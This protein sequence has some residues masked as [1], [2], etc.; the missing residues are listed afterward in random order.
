[1]QRLNGNGR[2]E[3]TITRMKL[4]N[5]NNRENIEKSKTAKIRA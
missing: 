3:S 2:T 5:L 4:S 1:M